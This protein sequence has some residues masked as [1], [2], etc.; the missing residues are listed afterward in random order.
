MVV[1][2]QSNIQLCRL[3]TSLARV[4]GAHLVNV[5]FD[6]SLVPKWSECF[7][8]GVEVSLGLVLGEPGE[9]GRRRRAMLTEGFVA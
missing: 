6:M 9:V 7:A 4:S 8:Y 3:L 2:G 1:G 5:A